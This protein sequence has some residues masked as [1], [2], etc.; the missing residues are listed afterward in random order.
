[1]YV[2]GK[3]YVGTED[4]EV[5]I[6]EHGPKLKVVNKVDMGELV[7]S[8]PVVANGTLYI[9]ARSKLYAIGNK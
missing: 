5:V 9:L 1:M 6:F 7:H 8:T 3:V 4:G 2:D